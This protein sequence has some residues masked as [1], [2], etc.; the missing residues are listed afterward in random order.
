MAEIVTFMLTTVYATSALLRV[1]ELWANR[2]RTLVDQV[3]QLCVRGMRDRSLVEI[4]ISIS[5]FREV[6]A[7]H[8]A[9]ALQGCQQLLLLVTYV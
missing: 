3:C 1:K 6:H 8:T 7:I 5:M 9:V 2:G 4:A